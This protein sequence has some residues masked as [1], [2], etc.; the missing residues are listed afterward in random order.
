MANMSI[1]VLI[2]NI[3]GEKTLGIIDYYRYPGLTKRLGG[4][5]NAQIFRKQIYLE[6]IKKIAFSA[7]VETGTYLGTTT[8]YLYKYSQLPVYTVELNPRHYGYVKT[9]FSMQNKIKVYHD[10][11]RNFL[12]KLSKDPSF[13]QKKVFFYLDAHWGEDLPLREEVQIIFENWF[14]AVV[15]IDDFK[16]P[17]D[18]KYGYDEYGGGKVLDLEYLNALNELELAAFFPSKRARFETGKKRG[19]VV[20]ARDP[21]LIEKLREFDAVVYYVNEGLPS[22]SSQQAD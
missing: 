9:R 6:L 12:K 20:L 13:I 17:S 8:Y 21:H 14:K 7:I 3:I 5:F 10:D 22:N 18:E 4:P 15:M 2:S 11:S 19:C 16:V 1:K